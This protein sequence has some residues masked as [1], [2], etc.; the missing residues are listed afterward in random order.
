M[1]RPVSPIRGRS[2]RVGV[3][4]SYNVGVV[5]DSRGWSDHHQRARSR[6][7]LRLVLRVVL[8]ATALI[9]FGGEVV[10]SVSTTKALESPASAASWERALGQTYCLAAELRH[11]VPKGALVYVNA[12]GE[13][14]PRLAEAAANWATP[15]S[16]RNQ[17]EWTLAFRRSPHGCN[18]SHLVATR[19]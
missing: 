17:A 1:R 15:V 16:A 10:H 3:A 4:S 5:N 18:G 14:D 19:T 9:I 8:V 12:G 7:A 13:I 6:P 11:A 2:P